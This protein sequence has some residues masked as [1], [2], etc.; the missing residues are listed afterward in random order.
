VTVSPFFPPEPAAIGPGGEASAFYAKVVEAF[1]EVA[2][3]TT[4]NTV[5]LNE[6]LRVVGQRLC[7]LL[8]VNR[9]SVYLRRDDGRFQGQVGYC[10]GRSIDSGVSK[11][12]SGTERDRFTSEIVETCAPVVV[13]DAA[14]DPRTIQ[15]TM[16]RWGVRDML[17]VPLV[18]DGDV[19]GIIYVD[20]EGATHEFGGRDVRL[21][22]AFARLC[23]LA[24][25]QAWLY[26]QLGE[27]A[28]TIEHQRRVLGDSATIHGR[29]TRAILDGADTA[30]ILR[31]LV[32]MLGKPVVLYGPT[33]AVTSWAAPDGLGLSKCPGLDAHQLSLPAV[34]TGIAALSNGSASTILRATPETRCRRLLVRLVVDR[35]CAGY[36]ELCEIGGMFSAVDSKA[37]EQ[38]AMAIALKLVTDQRNTELRQQ[39]REEFFADVMYA[40]RDLDALTSRAQQVGVSLDRGHVLARLEY[41]EGKSTETETGRQRRSQVLN[42]LGRE[43]DDEAKII[44]S[45]SV[46]GADLLLLEVPGNQALAHD[47]RLRCSLQRAV[48]QLVEHAALRLAVVSDACG[49]LCDLPVLA[50]RLRTTALMLGEATGAPR[51]VFAR[52]V[53]LLHH[54]G[55]RDGVSGALRLADELLMPLQEHDARNSGALLDTLRVV[56]ECQSQIRLAAIRLGVHE[57]TVR[58]RLSRIREISAIEPDRLDSLL[59]AAMALQVKQLYSATGETT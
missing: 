57:N 27:R 53:Y 2:L 29:V 6:V 48:P 15:R 45:T 41:D 40:R 47:G 3:L 55:Q 8:K 35:R 19:I 10:A 28:N 4:D 36:L 30:S 59:N 16:R 46:A 5:S 34:R 9:C 52:D 7:E 39:D 54:I 51:L 21:A 58:Y 20:H 42:L 18:V 38:A 44:A 25:R 31:L 13:R 11:L 32:E 22:E 26:Q 50:E 24:V 1:Q 49:R 56:V 23:A 43:L 12:V 37:L 17:G 14:Q 33:F